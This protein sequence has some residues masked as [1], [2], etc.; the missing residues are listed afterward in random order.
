MASAIRP[1]SRTGSPTRSAVSIDQPLSVQEFLRSL[2]KATRPLATPQTLEALQDNTST[3]CQL[4]VQGLLH[5]LRKPVTPL[6]K[7]AEAP[8][9]QTI[10]STGLDDLA[11]IDTATPASGPGPL[12]PPKSS[13]IEIDGE[14]VLSPLPEA[15]TL[16]YSDPEGADEKSVPMKIPS[17]T[18]TYTKKAKHIS[19]QQNDSAAL[20][21][22]QF[23]T[24]KGALVD[25][26]F[27]DGTDSKTEQLAPHETPK[28]KPAKK[29][30]SV[31]PKKRRQ[32][33]LQENEE[34]HREDHSEFDAD[35]VTKKKK[36]KTKRKKRRVPVNELA[37]MKELP[38]REA[39][40]ANNQVRRS[41]GAAFF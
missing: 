1:P 40:P 35:T 9:S 30:T 24:R 4:T 34:I 2:R 31:V 22:T 7:S 8:K 12:D 41:S 17:V 26:L 27:D 3:R 21:L 29:H 6:F 33:P 13:P 28:T 19:P 11:F 32:Q 23:S 36:E 37:L 15:Q 39:F 14:Q 16:R 10:A 18:R 25:R 38:S 5:G 20:F